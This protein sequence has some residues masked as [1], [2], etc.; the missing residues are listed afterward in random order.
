MAFE[1]EAF[2]FSEL[3]MGREGVQFERSLRSLAFTFNSWC[4][5]DG[6]RKPLYGDESRKSALEVIYFDKFAMFL[7]RIWNELF[8]QSYPEA[9]KDIKTSVPKDESKL[10]TFPQPFQEIPGKHGRGPGRFDAQRGPI[11]LIDILFE[12]QRDNILRYFD[13]TPP[14]DQPDNPRNYRTLVSSGI[15][16]TDP[17]QFLEGFTDLERDIL[18]DLANGLKRL[19]PSQIRAL[20]THENIY[21]TIQDVKKELIDSNEARQEI[22]KSLDN[23]SS[24]YNPSREML[25]YAEEAVRKSKTNRVDYGEA[26]QIIRREITN[27]KIIEA[28]QKSQSPPDVIWGPS[29][30]D[31]LAKNAEKLLSFSK[32]IHALAHYRNNNANRTTKSAK[33][34]KIYGYMWEEGLDEMAR[35]GLAGFPSKVSD[36]FINN[37]IDIQPAVQIHLMEVLKGVGIQQ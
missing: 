21:K 30:M 11:Y 8:R 4:G 22:I 27:A 33:E 14:S 19:G 10:I 20:G 16:F 2:L 17:Q 12:L 28:F 35:C 25:E 34:S 9:L 23:G 37:S 13:I 5:Y 36:V 26:F 6:S 32:Y 29:E 7:F 18:K 3:R 24:F 31:Y 1:E 15:L